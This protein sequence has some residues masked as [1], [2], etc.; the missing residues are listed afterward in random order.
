MKKFIIFFALLMGMFYSCLFVSAQANTNGTGNTNGT[1]NTHGTVN[2]NGTV[3]TTNTTTDGTAS[4]DAPTTITLDNPLHVTDVP[5][6]I[7]RI[8]KA[9][10][11]VV[12]S[13]ALLMFI[14]GGFYWMLSGGSTEAIAKGKNILIWA[15]VGLVVIFTSYA[16]V[17]FV[18]E[19][20]TKS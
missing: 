8:I 14:Y 2:T 18:I 15:A 7:G 19:S 12:G 9:I 6:L 3:N 16:L 4:G 1:V 10:L 13:L 11:S 20:L 5:T 17:S